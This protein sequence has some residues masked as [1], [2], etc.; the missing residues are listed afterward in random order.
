MRQRAFMDRIRR[1]L[2][3]GLG[4][5]GVRHR[6]HDVR[7]MADGPITRDDWWWE[8]D[9]LEFPLNAQRALN[10]TRYKSRLKRDV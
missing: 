10:K 5:F 6:D 3:G 4:G 9:D 7:H 2:A 8:G 1:G